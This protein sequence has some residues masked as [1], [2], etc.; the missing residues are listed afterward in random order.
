MWLIE[1]G[2]VLDFKNN[3]KLFQIIM[4]RPKFDTIPLAFEKM[5]LAFER[6]HPQSDI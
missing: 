4:K 1:K 6:S 5:L 3:G 2:K